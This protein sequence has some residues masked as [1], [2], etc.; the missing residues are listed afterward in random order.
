MQDE[1]YS[2]IC[3]GIRNGRL[4]EEQEYGESVYCFEGEALRLG[5]Q[6]PA[7]ARGKTQFDE[8]FSN[9]NVCVLN[10]YDGENQV[11]LV[12]NMSPETQ[13]IKVPA[14]NLL[15]SGNPDPKI[16]G[17]LLTTTE[18]ATLQDGILTLPPYSIVLLTDEI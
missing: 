9:E 12:F 14:V 5:R 15:K 3:T 17:L 2:S 7:I 11:E 8:E 18:T 13:R 4:Q 6:Y 1:S 10:R 16:A